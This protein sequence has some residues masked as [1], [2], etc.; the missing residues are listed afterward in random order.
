[1]DSVAAL[2]LATEAPTAGLLDRRPYCRNALLISRPMWRNIIVQTAFQLILLFVLL[3]VG[4]SWFKIP[5]GISCEGYSTSSTASDHR[6]DLLN[7]NATSHSAS[8]PFVISCHTF[9]EVCS[10]YGHRNHDCLYASH[11][12]SDHYG[13]AENVTFSFH[14]LSGF[15][16]HC[17]TCTT[18]NW[19][20]YTIIFNTF[21]F[22]QIFNEFNCRSIF[23]DLNVFKGICGNPVFLWVIF[24]ITASQVDMC[25]VTSTES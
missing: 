20:H 4:P 17:L 5:A 24:A 2:A 19:T 16:K 13:D 23:D 14:S 22:C 7:G 6:W 8:S 25:A 3:W 18:F 15:E 12:L 21:V 10:S 1:M 11:T 9:R